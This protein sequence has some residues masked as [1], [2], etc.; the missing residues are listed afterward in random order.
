MLQDRYK[1]VYSAY[2]SFIPGKYLFL[3]DGECG[4][5]KEEHMLYNH[6]EDLYRLAD[7]CGGPVYSGCFAGLNEMGI[8]YRLFEDMHVPPGCTDNYIMAYGG[9][10]D[11]ERKMLC[12]LPG[13][14]NSFL[15][16]EKDFPLECIK[17][18]PANSKFCDALTHRDFLGTI[19]GVTGVK[20]DQIGDIII[21]KGDNG[22]FAAGYVFC[23]KDKARFILDITRMRHT[24]VHTEIADG[25]MLPLVQ[26]YKD[27]QGSVSSMR[28]DCIV[29]V[30]LKMSRSKCLALVK[31]GSVYINGRL[32]TEGSKVLCDGDIISIRGYGKYKAG[33]S[34]SVTKKGRYHITV[35][36]YI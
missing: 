27:I 29:A 18:S 36:Q 2:S 15:P 28:L 26:E 31:A 25:E 33:L 20:R 10:K 7:T 6:F 8:I 21:K 13:T 34:Q 19:M 11:A 12:F 3:S 35:K 4:M 16:Q 23:C 1:P 24:T 14:N 22:S 30:A 32:C 9:Y 5:T 17:I